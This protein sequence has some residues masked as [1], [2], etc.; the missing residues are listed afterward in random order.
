MQQSQR[1][2]RSACR[3]Q[4]RERAS[5]ELK[6]AMH[7]ESDSHGA[8][9]QTGKRR[10]YLPETANSPIGGEQGGG[11]TEAAGR[12]RRIGRYGGELADSTLCRISQRGEPVGDRP[13]MRR[14]DRKSTRLN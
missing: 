12:L 6:Q 8:E 7:R 9:E 4:R 1:E 2:W 3:P 11:V 14:L 13:H 5:P 10:H